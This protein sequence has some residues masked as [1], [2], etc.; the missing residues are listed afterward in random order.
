MKPEDV[1]DEMIEAV[2]FACGYGTDGWG[3]ADPKEI[4]AAS[5][6]VVGQQRLRL[7]RV[8]QEQLIKGL[9]YLIQD[10]YGYC[11][12]MVCV[13]WPPTGKPYVS[14]ARSDKIYG[15]LPE[16]ELEDTK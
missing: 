9:S 5:V 1:T 13:E 15:P 7:P 10:R 11:S 8:A 3:S 14:S 2:E 4:I 12:F 16:F 6:N